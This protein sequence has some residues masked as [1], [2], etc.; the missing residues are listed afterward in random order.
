MSRILF[1]WFI[2]LWCA[3]LWPA[4]AGAVNIPD[5]GGENQRTCKWTDQE[6]YDNG[7]REC[8]YDLKGSSGVCVNELRRVWNRRSAWLEWAL[9]Q[10]RY[11]VQGGEPVHWIGSIGGHNAYSSLHQG[12]GYD[13][14]NHKYS[15]TDQL[16]MGARVLEIDPHWSTEK[17]RVCHFGSSDQ[18]FSYSRLMASLLD[19]VA[20]WLDANPD[21]IIFLKFDDH[22]GSHIDDFV[23][24]VQHYL[25]NKVY[26]RANNPRS[27]PTLAQMKAAGTQVLI[28]TRNNKFAGNAWFW[29]FDTDYVTDKDHPDQIST[30]S[31]VDGDGRIVYKR[32]AWMWSAVAE[33][34]SWSNTFDQTGLIQPN[35]GTVAAL[36]RCGVSWIGLD[37]LDALDSPVAGIFKFSGLDTRIEESIWSFERNEY[38]ANGPMFMRG[39]TGRWASGPATSARRFA[40]LMPAPAG[41]NTYSREF[42]V[43][44]KADVWS[45]GNDTCR[46]EFGSTASFGAPTLPY[47]NAQLAAASSGGEV[48]LSYTLVAQIDPLSQPGRRSFSGAAG[49]PAGT[50]ELLV[51]ARPALGLDLVV[52][53]AE[54]WI[55][56]N[57]L[58]GTVPLE[59]GNR[60]AITIDPASAPRTPGNYSGSISLGYFG[61]GS[62]SQVAVSYSVTREAEVAL[63]FSANPVRQPTGT[64]ATVQLRSQVAGQPLTGGTVTLREVI[65]G[66]DGADATFRVLGTAGLPSAAQTAVV[67]IALNSITVGAGRHTVFADYTGGVNHTSSSSPASTLQIDPRI[68]VV[69]ASV[70]F[71][72]ASGGPL[73][74]AQLVKVGGNSAPAFLAKLPTWASASTLNGDLYIGL[75]SGALQFAAGTFSGTFIVGDGTG[76]DTQ[77]PIGVN[78]ALPTGALPSLVVSTAGVRRDRSVPLRVSNTGRGVAAAAQLTSVQIETL[79]GNAAVTLP[80]SV[81]LPLGSIAAGGAQDINLPLRWPAGAQRVRLTLSFTSNSGAY[82]V[83][84]TLNLMR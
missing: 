57:A 83:N 11:G 8:E 68:Q 50:R 55:V 78:V 25:G 5:C 37:Y 72:M 80:G 81:P 13:Q 29:F 40:C 71:N 15:V 4:E 42:R 76:V 67:N 36:L 47:L 58:D 30:T 54:S 60:Y 45:R 41:T 6:Y 63:H 75:N 16:R 53:S 51:L 61:A 65:P 35:S 82:T 2:A 48:W 17:P 64:T 70:T 77:V 20:N 43:T 31:C 38:G 44:N 23:T 34:R 56:V 12:F 62:P 28:G 14:S 49:A 18:C 7:S 1:T 59:Q 84:R 24:L 27:W 79:V 10:Q 9:R 19:E 73:P 32:P 39:N 26:K 22:V 74:A 66:V 69:P 3:M 21:E 46:A 33:G 52:K